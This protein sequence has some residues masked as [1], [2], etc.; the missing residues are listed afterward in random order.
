ML[1]VGTHLVSFKR[2]MKAR[3]HGEI[4]S[5]YGGD[6]RG[7][8]QRGAVDSPEATLELEK[9]RV[10]YTRDTLG[11]IPLKPGVYI[12]RDRTTEVL[13]VGK[14][15]KLR[16]RVR[17][18]FTDGGDGRL[19]VAF[20]QRRIATVEIITTRNEKEALLLENALIKHYEP[21]YNFRLTDDKSYYAIKLDRSKKY[22]RLE[23][24]RTHGLQPQRSGKTEYFGPYHSSEAVKSSISLLQK[25]FPLRTCTDHVMNNRTRPCLLHE[26]GK[27]CGPCVLDV[28]DEE[29]DDLI[30]GARLFLSGRGDE[31]KS[32]LKNRMEGLSEAMEFE[33]AARV[34]D[35]LHAVE[36]TLETQTVQSLGQDSR[37]VVAMV[38]QAGSICFVVLH[39]RADGLEEAEHFIERDFSESND[40]VMHLFLTQYYAAGREVP[41]HLWV[42]S[43]PRDESAVK[44]FLEE[45]LHSGAS[46]QVVQ[47][48]APQRGEKARAVEMAREN[49]AEILEREVAGRKSREEIMAN[50]QKKL[51]LPEPPR[52]IEC[53][54]IATF[55][56]SANV[57]AMIC[58]RNGEPDKSNYRKY[59]LK[60][61]PEG[62][63]DDFAAMHEVLTRRY[64]RLVREKKPLPDLVL[65]DGG[66]GQLSMA[67]DVLRNLGVR[68]IPLAALAKSR[69]KLTSGRGTKPGAEKHR[70]E[71]RIFLPGRK[72][73]V[74][75]RRDSPA[76][77]L[78]QR[79]RDETHRFVNTFHRQRRS[80]NQL[81]SVLDDIPGIGP[82]RRKAL[83]RHF[84]SLTKL[85]QA[86]IEQLA[87]APQMSKKLAEAVSAALADQTTNE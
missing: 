45:L 55:Q 46:F 16:Q 66:R 29:Y 3:K 50:L 19:N 75:F 51:H 5:A 22:P 67:E 6:E 20:M 87:E 47:L 69:L 4:P 39:Y 27:C 84:G 36:R 80:K 43:P 68:E 60:S 12:M 81:H 48:L 56:G 21:R 9:R 18:Y 83:L 38:R 1:E 41:R 59:I 34:R 30:D 8:F 23:F 53:F 86:N 11:E 85:R 15:V 40:E 14:S 70:T 7:R 63:T 61:V 52:H 44:E 33:K 31:V 54:D 73:P 76:L 74:L 32:R 42:S 72:N 79:V 62:K 17:A 25:I 58:F 49:A 78:L 24:V 37:D 71:E 65:I 82:A 26:I 64:S 28:S 35:G 77:Y 10:A 57:A 13:Y 2:K